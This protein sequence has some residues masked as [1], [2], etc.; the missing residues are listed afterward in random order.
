MERMNI[1]GT[2]L[3][4][5]YDSSKNNIYKIEMKK[6]FDYKDIDYVLNVFSKK[7]PYN[8]RGIYFV[9][10]KTSY[11]KMLFLLNN[12]NNNNNK[13]KC[14]D[15]VEGLLTIKT[16]KPEIYELY[17]KENDSNIS[18]GYAYIPNTRVSHKMEDLFKGNDSIMIKY[19]YNKV[20]QRWEPIF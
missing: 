17:K 20:F 4:D 16:N 10:I 15:N 13:N 1:I 7:L 14:S 19:K 2:I 6:Y 18:I 5:S 3:T 9:P 11:S 12:N 8:V